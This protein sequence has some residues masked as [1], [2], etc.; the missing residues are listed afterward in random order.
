MNQNE[1]PLNRV[2]PSELTPTILFED[3]HL[4]VLD[5][6]AGLLSQGEHTGDLNLV[7][8]LRGYFG[9]HYVGLVHRLD[10]N[11]SG[12]MVVAKRT[13][14]AQRLTESL[15]KGAL[16]RSYIT[17]VDGKVGGPLRL[18]HF[19]LKNEKTNE[20]RVVP[21]GTRGA[22]VALLDARPVGTGCYAGCD[23]TLL[24]VELET[25]RSHQIRVQLAAAGHPLLGDRKYAKKTALHGFPRPALHSCRIEFPH[26]MG[27]EAV[28]IECP[29]PTDMA[30]VRGR[31]TKI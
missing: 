27:G 6:P 25:G 5:K 2:F 18:K 1:A 19:L 24:E 16:R 17:W 31:G 3:T 20:V 14:S 9:R 11:T 26:P 21:E 10:R 30:E 22:K 12:L 8:W 28:R 13:K 15:Q 4:V 7:D 29:L 23:L